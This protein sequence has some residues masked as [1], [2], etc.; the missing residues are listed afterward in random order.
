MTSLIYFRSTA[1]VQNANGELRIIVDLDREKGKAPRIDR[2]T[3]QPRQNSTR[4]RIKK[5]GEIRMAV[6]QAYLDRTM[7]FDT[8]VLEAIS[9]FTF[10]QM[11]LN[12]D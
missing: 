3:G 4:V 7:P 6:I 9:K 5:V 8:T 1:N 11:H 10:C 12:P 2:A